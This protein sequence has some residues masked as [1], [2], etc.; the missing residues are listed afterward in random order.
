MRH[1][2]AFA[3]SN[4]PDDACEALLCSVGLEDPNYLV[5]HEAA[6]ALMT[7]GSESSLECL[8]RGLLDSNNE[9]IVSCR[10]AISSIHYRLS[11][12][13]HIHFPTRRSIIKAAERS[14]RL[15]SYRLHMGISA[16]RDLI[17]TSGDGV[18]LDARILKVECSRAAIMLVHGFGV[19]LHE[20]GTFDVLVERLAETSFSEM[21][22]SFRGHGDSGGKQEE[23]TIS[24]ERLDLLAAY[25][26]L[27]KQLKPPY[28]IIAASFG[29]VSTLLELGTLRPMPTGLVLWNPVL[30]IDSVFV[31]PTTPWGRPILVKRRLKLRQMPVTPWLTASSAL[32]IFSS[33]RCCFI[34]A[35]LDLNISRGFRP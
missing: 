18:E 17:M 35:I 9:V 13:R 33:K 5:R 4:F 20:E 21:R 23:M 6:I 25:E 24:G 15:D 29:A 12:R 16:E 7:V 14:F 1:E 19:D 28:V 22:F 32:A 31:H 34:R 30:D 10:L 3:L 27:T 11:H 8:E 26:T 2:A